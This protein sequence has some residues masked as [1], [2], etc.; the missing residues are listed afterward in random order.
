MEIDRY[1]I[2]NFIAVY[3]RPVLVYADNAMSKTASGKGGG[4]S[5]CLK[6]QVY[7]LCLDGKDKSLFSGP[8]DERMTK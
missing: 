8:F 7:D 5:K 1:I 6:F 2:F 3:G 4:G